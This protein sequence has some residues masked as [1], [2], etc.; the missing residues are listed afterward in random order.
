MG[1]A[2][3]SNGVASEDPLATSFSLSTMMPLRYGRET[4]EQGLKV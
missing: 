4:E 3:C 2:I 1:A